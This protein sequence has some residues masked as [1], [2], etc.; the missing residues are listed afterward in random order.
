MGL[1]GTVFSV[2]D[3]YSRLQTLANFSAL[4]PDNFK[5]RNAFPNVVDLKENALDAFV[6]TGFFPGFHA[7]CRC[8]IV[9]L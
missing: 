1:H 5:E 7:D 9:F 2:E 3:A 8:G 4:D 6:Q